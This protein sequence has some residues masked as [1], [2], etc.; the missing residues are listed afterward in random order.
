MSV[1]NSGQVLRCCTLH[2]SSFLAMAIASRPDALSHIVSRCPA[3]SHDVH[4]DCTRGAIFLFLT[5]FNGS[6]EIVQRILKSEIK[7]RLTDRGMTTID[8]KARVKFCGVSM[9]HQ[10][11][12][13][14]NRIISSHE[15][16]YNLR[17]IL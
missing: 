16:A 12:T 9:M 2:V 8:K 6:D 3:S 13:K 10:E 17:R 14:M 11:C 5:V 1:S 7:L 4:I 15:I